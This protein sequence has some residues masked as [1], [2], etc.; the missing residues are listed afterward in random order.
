M[1][2]SIIIPVYNVEQYVERCLKS[3]M[4]QTYHGA[5]ECLIVD[6]CGLDKSMEI[7]ERLIVDYHGLIQFKILHHDHNRGLSGARNTGMEAATGDYIYFLDSDDEISLDCIEKLVEPLSIE[8]YDIIVG[9]I[10]TIGD[11]QDLNLSLKLNDGVVLRGREIQDLYRIKWNMVSVNKLYR[12]SFIRQQKLQFKEGLI[13]E[14]EL[15]SLQVACLAKSLRAVARGTYNYYIRGGSI[16]SADTRE[17]KAKMLKVIASE[18]CKFLKDRKIYSPRAYQIMQIF[19]YGS[20]Q[21]SLHDKDRF[22]Q[23]YCELRKVTHL[24]LFYRIMAG[25][26]RL[27]IQLRNLYYILPPRLAAQILYLRANK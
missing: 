17:R 6:D 26:W 3:V 11:T 23:D 2:V 14:D 1:K 27:Q 16:T 19:S 4:A 22:V 13:H 10:C 12:T 8:Q 20:L 15:W 7:V 21:S 24:P 9:N 18:I 5:M 25:R